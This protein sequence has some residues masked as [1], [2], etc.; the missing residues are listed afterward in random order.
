MA[1]RQSESAKNHWGARCLVV[2]GILASI[3]IANI[4]LGKAGVTFGWD[5]PFLLSDV[6]EYLILLFAALFFT[7]AT[8]IR[9]SR[10]D[11]HDGD[12]GPDPAS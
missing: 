8:L 4:L 2:F 7:I 3:F 5:V 6:G 10:A 9:E 12:P 1:G 11:A